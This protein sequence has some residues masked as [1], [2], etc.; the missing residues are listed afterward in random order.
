MTKEKWVTRCRT[1][2]VIEDDEDL[3]EVLRAALDAEGFC[4]RVVGNGQDG[5]KILRETDCI[6]LILLDL[7]MP[8]MNSWEFLQARKDEGRLA[9][10]PVVILSAMDTMI[11]GDGATAW[12]EKPFELDLLFSI[13]RQYCRE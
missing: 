1:V 11:P 12:L 9:A 10:I 5:L 6:C 8:V 7:A 2:L 3:R 13:V 4:V